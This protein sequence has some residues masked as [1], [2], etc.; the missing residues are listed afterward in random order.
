MVDNGQTADDL[1]R[2]GLDLHKQG[3]LTEACPLYGAALVQAPGHAEALHL[4]GLAAYQQGDFDG[5][6]LRI[7]AAIDRRPD[8]AKY[9]S[10]RGNVLKEKGRLEDAI[11]AYRRAID[12]DPAF[13]DASFN[14]GVALREA[15]D[16]AG[17]AQAFQA[18]LKVNPGNLDARQNL[19]TILFSLGRHDHAITLF[20]EVLKVRPNAPEV[21]FNLSQTLERAG[22]YAEA[23]DE[24]RAALTL[25]PTY[26]AAAAALH[27]LMR[28]CCVW[29]DLAEVAAVVDADI[30]AAGS[31]GRVAETPFA[32]VGRCDDPAR[33]LVVSRAWGNAVARAAPPLFGQSLR[34]QTRPDARLRLG[35][36]SSDMRNHPVG[37]LMRG[38]L[39]RHDRS[40]F[41]I[42]IYSYGANDGGALRQDLMQ[43]C[44]SFVDIRELAHHEA[45]RR[46]HADDIDI[47]IDL[48]G[49]TRGHRMAIGAH[50][51]APVQVC[52]LG[53]P[54]TT[55]CPFI[56]YAIVDSVVV[57]QDHVAHFSE[58]LV[59]M[60]DCYL[61]TDD[62]QA[63]AADG[64]SRA[65]AGLPADGFV[66]CS[67]NGP[68]KID[69]IMFDVW[70]RILAAVPESVLWLRH[71]DDQADANLRAEAARR[72]VSGERLIFARSVPGKDD[73][74]FRMGLADLALDTRIYN[75]HTTTADTLWAGVPVVAIEGGHFASRVASSCLKAVGLPELVTDSLD[76]YEALA[77]RLARKP[78]ELGPL[79]E[80]LAANRLIFPLFDTARFARHLE[81]AFETMWRRHLAGDPPAPIVVE[82]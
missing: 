75:G 10:N 50:R 24:A 9:H 47:L 64:P 52:Y 65:G 44:E 79:R 51:P 54:G 78:D 36:L 30:N 12:L 74:L 70:M 7:E 2:R 73:H 62:G 81:H 66:F 46:I 41:N 45:A 22:R 77:I 42:S 38:L 49:W 3:R 33:N 13:T 11:A 40:R 80:R 32:H 6:L 1:V 29:T 63:I 26:A 17:S 16:I 37:Q 53:Y 43:T 71:G 55:G 56:D 27:F 19:A 48:N 60:P 68:A 69:P 76:A 28:R 35:Y 34:S 18:V 21:H 4:L 8:V 31:G 58:A 57:P 25:A 5:A 39:R 20:R 15:G 72:G 82:S 23:M 61:V 14:L 59:F 67:F